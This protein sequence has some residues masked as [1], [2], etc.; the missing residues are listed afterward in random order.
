[1]NRNPL[2]AFALEARRELLHAACESAA[3]N[4]PMADVEA[5]AFEWF[6]RLVAITFMERHGYLANSPAGGNTVLGR[7]NALHQAMPF[8]FGLVDDL[9]NCWERMFQPKSLT[10]QRL[11]QIPAADWNDVEIIGWLYQ[12]YIS[13]RKTAA[14]GKVIQSED[15]PAA[16]Q[17]F[18]PSWIV[19]YLVQN[20]LGARWMSA[21]PNSSLPQQM[22]YYIQPAEQSAE[23]QQQLHA[24]PCVRIA[25]E[26]LTVLD[27]ACGA[28]HMLAEAYDLL[29]AIYQECGRSGEAIPRLILENNLVGLEIDDRAAKLASLAL[30]MKAR[31]DDPGFFQRNVRPQIIA[32]QQSQG[33]DATAIAEALNQPSAD[34]L[35]PGEIAQADVAQLVD[36]FEHGK[37]FGSLLQTSDCNLQPLSDRIDEVMRRGTPH[38]Q[39]VIAPF[40]T[41]AQQARVLARRFEV[42]VANPPYMGRRNGMNALLKGFAEEHFPHGKADLFAMFMERGLLF[43]NQGGHVAMVTMHSW[44]FLP[45]FKHLRQHLMENTMLTTLAHLGARAFGMISGEVVQ[46]AAFSC[47]KCALPNYRPT[48]FRLLEG[49]EEEKQ[50]ALQ[51][52]EGRFTDARQSDLATIPGGPIAYWA[53]PAIRAAFTTGQSLG[54]VSPVRQGMATADNARFLRY[55]FEV[56]ERTIGRD[57]TTAETAKASARKWFPYNK[58]GTHRKWFGN[59]EHVVLWENDGQELWANRPQ[60]V[61]RN[62]DYYFRPGI[63][64]SFVSTARFGVRQCGP[65]FLFDVGGSSTFPPSHLRDCVTGFLCSKVALHL[66]QILNPTFNYQVG[67]VASLPLPPSVLQHPP[68]VSD[69]V[70]AAVAIAKADCDSHETSPGFAS[71]FETTPP[72]AS[73]SD[74]LDRVVEQ[75]RQRRSELQQL[76]EAN[77]RFFINA[78]GLQEEM[79]PDAPDEQITLTRPDRPAEC[80]RLI[81][82]A[83][84]CM[85]GRYSLDQSGVVY[86]HCGNV[87]FD[88]RSY[89]TFPATDDGILPVTNRR[90]FD[91]DAAICLER[92][93]QTVWPASDTPANMAT[94]AALLSPRKKESPTATIRR[95]LAGQFYKD[96]CSAYRKRPIYWL[97]CSGKTQGFQALVYLHRFQ[98]QTLTQMVAN[99]VVPLEAKLV[100]QM[101]RRTKKEKEQAQLHQQLGE[102]RAYRALLSNYAEQP[103]NLHLD[104]GVK[105]NHRQFAALLSATKL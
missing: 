96:H 33:L 32:L 72:G 11:S 47:R 62:A 3:D 93:V 75:R 43:A 52:R 98:K 94:I 39:Q 87:G 18:T 41:I 31:A 86:A 100:E 50:Q 89:P 95:Y 81:S 88:P 65:G 12:C 85:L 55:W 20:S 73:V 67:N 57:Y 27:P 13:E 35:A 74:Y 30:M 9:P 51:R 5:I 79:S 26:Q 7:C 1:M 56:S 64:W 28:G 40:Q 37:T 2:K 58:G 102:V 6:A 71:L 105:A 63:T 91:N 66:M 70:R 78:Y 34:H 38:N 53:S 48:F 77:N 22:E 23:V 16:T 21:H 29:K 103:F 15:I 60:S 36:R 83:I 76:E 46:V 69:H 104:D 8:L 59:N 80:R 4:G 24:M 84:G 19:K 10:Q 45:T 97:F 68:E 17:L 82:Y 14:I 101:K 92:F 42:I 25:P 61:I 90:W 54:D 44:M 99:Y 49:S